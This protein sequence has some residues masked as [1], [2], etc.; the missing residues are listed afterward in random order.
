M[1]SE[2][3]KISLLGLYNAGKSSFLRILDNKSDKLQS[4]GKTTGLNKMEVDILGFKLDYFDFGGFKE[5]RENFLEKK[6]NYIN[7]NLFYYIVD[8]QDRRS[9]GESVEFFDKILK[10]LEKNQVKPHFIICFHKCDPELISNPTSYIHEN[11][12]FVQNLFRNRSKGWDIEFLQTSIKD[13]S[14]LVRAFTKGLIKIFVDP[15]HIMNTLFKDFMKKT[16]FDGICLLDQDGLALFELY[17]KTPLTRKIIDIIGLN[18]AQMSEK[19]SSY[20]IGVPNWIQVDMKGWTFFKTFELE[21][22]KR[23]YII[24][25]SHDPANFDIVNKSLPYYAD[26]ISNAMEE[27]LLLISNK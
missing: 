26:T 20:N 9:F 24:I 5:H 6:V 7:T 23:Y 12:K 14:S 10:E 18:M 8:A 19:L 13:F 15:P 2:W 1:G 4:L 25:Y 17:N 16:N 11:L 21:K 3:Y 27:I 22:E